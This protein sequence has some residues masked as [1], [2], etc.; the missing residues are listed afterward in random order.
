MSNTSSRETTAPDIA[1]LVNPKIKSEAPKAIGLG[2]DTNRPAPKEVLVKDIIK[3]EEFTGLVIGE[4]GYDFKLEKSV[5]PHPLDVNQ[6]VEVIKSVDPDFSL[7]IY[8]K[9]ELVWPK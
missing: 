6:V 8:F 3:P 2:K 4:V 1:I 5:E 7:P 9:G